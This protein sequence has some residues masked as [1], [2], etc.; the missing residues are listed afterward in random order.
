MKKRKHIFAACVA[1]VLLLIFAVMIFVYLAWFTPR[2]YRM[3]VAL[4][5]YEEVLD[6]VWL[7]CEYTG[8]VDLIYD[9][10][11]DARNRVES[12][13]GELK[14]SPVLIITENESKL[15]RIGGDSDIT[16]FSVGAVY[17]YISVGVE[18]WNVDTVAHELAH[19]EIH[20]RLFDGKIS[21]DR[22]VPPWFDEGI[23]LQLDYNTQYSWDALL[24]YTEDM[25]LLPDFEKLSNEEYFYADDEET[26]TYNYLAAKYE[27][28]R[29]LLENGGEK[30][31]VKLLDAINRGEDFY[32][33]YDVPM[34]D[35]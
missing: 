20:K 30:E 6:G 31:L 8:D 34:I 15:H 10:V 3:T 2:G 19:A 16:S 14:A 33:L 28:G 35:K 13:F 11:Y 17:S 7:D 21:F 27:V 32:K 29:W 9:T 26:L 22:T 4:H 5:G 23:A 12:F 25:T 18:K 24:R 1:A